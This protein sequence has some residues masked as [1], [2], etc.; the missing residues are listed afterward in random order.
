MRYHR[1][2]SKGP[3]WDSPDGRSEDEV[4]PDSMLEDD[5]SEREE[6]IDEEE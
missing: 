1:H 2:Y 6:E 3:S 4:I 5:D